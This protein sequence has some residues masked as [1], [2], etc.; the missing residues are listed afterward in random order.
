MNLHKRVALIFSLFSVISFVLNVFTPTNPDHLL[1]VIEHGCLLTIF[2]LTYFLPDRPSG[3]LQIIALSVAA[4]IPMGLSDSP[5]F[6]AVVAVF[7]LVLIYAYGGYQSHKGWKMTATFLSLFF[8]CA[9]ASSNFMPPS[10]EMYVRSFGWA[11]F[12]SVFCFVLWLIVEDIKRQF[13]SSFAT[14]IIT[15]NRELLEL[16]KQLARE[17]ADVKHHT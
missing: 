7:V 17:C 14:E 10:L 12:I 8:I 2:I 3:V 5:F 13:F 4:I 15:Q 11:L 9:I 6:G 1:N 16:N